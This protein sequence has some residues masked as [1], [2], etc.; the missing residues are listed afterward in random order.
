LVVGEAQPQVAGWLT[1]YSVLLAQA[2]DH[3][4]FAW[5]HPSNSSDQDKLE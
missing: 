5:I 1:D 4:Q 2:F 3:L